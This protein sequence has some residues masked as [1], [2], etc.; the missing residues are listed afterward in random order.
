MCERPAFFCFTFSG[1]YIIISLAAQLVERG[2]S[3]VSCV[4]TWALL[5]T[6][7]LRISVC[8]NNRACVSA[9]TIHPGKVSRWCAICSLHQ[10]MFGEHATSPHFTGLCSCSAVTHEEDYT[11]ELAAS[12]TQHSPVR[13]R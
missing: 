8:S 3:A 1:V 9:V 13:W 12:F 2:A 7:C 10:L 11:I 6:E 4:L 5:Y